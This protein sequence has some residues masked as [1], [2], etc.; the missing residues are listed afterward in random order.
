MAE[1]INL[2]SLVLIHYS[3]AM[4]NGT[5]IESSFDEEPLQV[6]M[7]SGQLTDGMELAIVGLEEGVEQTLTLTP[8]QCFG[9]RDEANIHD[10][11][12]ADFTDELRP[13]T[14]LTFNF[15]TDDGHEILGTIRSVKDETVEVDFNHPLAGH[16]LIFSV[17]I[18]G[19]NNAH[20]QIEANQ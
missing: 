9:E 1:Q 8:E 15:G 14:G 5:V 17:K 12:L 11:P 4:T 7:G 10:M 6:T 19:I 18:L 13:E 16:A 2:N 3:L 20:A